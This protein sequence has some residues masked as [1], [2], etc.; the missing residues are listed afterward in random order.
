MKEEQRLIRVK[1]AHVSKFD[2]RLRQM[3]ARRRNK[4]AENRL[5]A[6]VNAVKRSKRWGRVHRIKTNY[7]GASSRSS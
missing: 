6:P 1:S 3:V 4:I 2:I 7:A 5:E